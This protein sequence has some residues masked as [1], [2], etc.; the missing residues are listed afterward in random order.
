MYLIL[1]RIFDTIFALISIILLMPIFLFISLAIK[2]EDQGQVIYW[3]ERIG[4]ERE[5]LKCQNLGLWL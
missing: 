5:P 1:K 4:K 2:L 3:S